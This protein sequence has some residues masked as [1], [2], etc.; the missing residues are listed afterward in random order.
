MGKRLLSSFF[1]APGDDGS[2]GN[3]GEMKLKEK[4]RM[5]FYFDKQS[6]KQQ[7]EVQAIHEPWSTISTFF[8]VGSDG[9]DTMDAPIAVAV[10]I[11]CLVF[12]TCD[13]TTVMLLPLFRVSEVVDDPGRGGLGSD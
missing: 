6:R 3:N 4:E 5:G 9:R 2:L 13:G 8:F 11:E 1:A 10:A 12:G 7:G